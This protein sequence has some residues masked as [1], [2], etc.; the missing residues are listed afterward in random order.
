MENRKATEKMNRKRTVIVL[1]IFFI[2]IAAGGFVVVTKAIEA[3]QSEEMTARPE[4]SVPVDLAR[5]TVDRIQEQRR[6][7]GTLAADAQFMVSAKIAG[8]LQSLLVDIGDEV[9]RGQLVAVLDD[10]ERR[11]AVDESEAELLVARANLE[12]AESALELLERDY[13]RTRNLRDR[14]VVSDSDLDSAR[15]QLDAARSRV[16]V[17]SAQL[18]QRQAAL[19][20]ERVRL[21]YSEVRANWQTGGDRRV[22][23]ERFVDE[24]TTLSANEPIIS[25]LDIEALRAVI[26][27]TERDYGRMHIGQP[28]VLRVDGYPNE[29][30]HGEVVRMAPLFRENSRQ[31]RVEISVVNEDGRLKPGMFLRAGIVMREQEE[32][33]TVPLDAVVR[34]NG[35]HGVFL[36]DRET[37]VANFVPVETGIVEG[38]RVQIVSPELEG[39]VVTLGQHL[40]SDGMAI[41]MQ[42]EASETLAA[43]GRELEVLQ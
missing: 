3:S 34:R 11:L 17:A 6:F 41:R 40:L 24:G 26:F 29:E 25:V 18:N 7:S 30:F 27:V 23:G 42:D 20:A 32:A 5:V 43:G 13:E 35:E 22:V 39:Y 2:A 37:H 4:Q 12:E 28:A 15:L 1:A 19:D 14:E 9:E 21:E 33:V 8:R 16:R 31:A 38:T 10:E 36:A